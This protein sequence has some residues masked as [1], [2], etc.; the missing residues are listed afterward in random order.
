MHL[1]VEKHF[2]IRSHPLFDWE[3]AFSRL[4]LTEEGFP[5]FHRILGVLFY[6]GEGWG[7]GDCGMLHFPA[8]TLDTMYVYH[9]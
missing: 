9:C 1:A 2:R 3:A 8:D 6:S 5:L 4:T 7:I